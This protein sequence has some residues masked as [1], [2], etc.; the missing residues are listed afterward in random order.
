MQEVVLR[1]FVDNAALHMID[2][3]SQDR[4]GVCALSEAGMLAHRQDSKVFEVVAVVGSVHEELA[5]LQVA[6]ENC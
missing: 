1:V 4:G 3:Y 5:R 2:R 6:S